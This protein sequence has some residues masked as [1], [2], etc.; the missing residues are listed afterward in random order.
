VLVFRDMTEKQKLANAIQQSQKLASLGILA[1]GIAHD[2]NNIL[3]GIFGFIELA[4]GKNSED[5]VS[6]Y[7][8]RSLQA[9]DR[10]RALTRQLMTFA[11]GDSPI[12][13]VGNI[14]P[15]IQETVLF[16]LSGSAISCKFLIPENTWPCNFD[17]NQIGQVF[18]NLTINARQ[19]MPDGGSLEVSAQNIRLSDKERISLPAGNY[20]KLSIKDQ[21]SGIPKEYQHRIF[22]PYFTTKPQG[23]GLGLA[24]C[25]AIIN[26]H[27]GS[28]DVESEP[29]QGCT[30][31]VY[32]PASTTTNITD[33]R[34]ITG[35]HSGHGVFLVM[36]DDEDMREFA[37]RSLE[38]FGYDV[39]VTDNGK[40]AVDIFT[41]EYKVNHKLTGIIFDLT[42]PGG[43]GGAE[44][45]SE[46]RKLCQDTPAFVSSGYSES[47]VMADPQKYGFNDSIQK[48]FT[49]A[50]LSEM[51]DKHLKQ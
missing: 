31:H 4:L 32:L 44:A 25:Y 47:S 20:V 29:G 36:D 7:L 10:A 50:E 16:A 18:D 3:S 9:I 27:G 34:K 19:A 1:G 48:P 23:H 49:R 21:G 5:K 28:L 42:V 15:F 39:E 12:R 40:D 8:A 46:I 45:I 41:A 37:K 17:S 24:T 51:L 43:M 11:K 38:S 30:F 2:F 22:D 13:T 26:R 33:V 6:D 14:S 35:I